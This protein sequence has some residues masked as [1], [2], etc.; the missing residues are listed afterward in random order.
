MD[1]KSHQ[2]NYMKFYATITNERDSRAGKK[3]GNEF[4]QVEL[5]A[6]GKIVGFVILEITEDAQGEP[7]QYNLKFASYRDA[8]DWVMLKQGHQSEGVIQTI[9]A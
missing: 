2:S 1:S 3:G 7:L 8:I 4:L 9:Q 6:F 5:T